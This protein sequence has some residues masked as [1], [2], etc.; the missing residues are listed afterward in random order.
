MKVL[1]KIKRLARRAARGVVLLAA[2][3][4]FLEIVMG[5]VGVP[6]WLAGWLTGAGVVLEA[7]PRYVVVLG[8]GG[9]P[10]GS[11]LMRTYYAA[12]VGAVYTGA[13][14]V[15]SLPARGDPETSSV[16]RMKQELVMRGIPR[17]SIRMEHEALNTREQA[18]N[19][20]R[21]LG[22][23][24]LDDAVLMVTSPEHVR[25]ALL[26]F[27]KAGFAQVAPLAALDT[28]AEADLGAMTGARYAFW[29]RLQTQVVFA[30]ELCALAVYKLRGWI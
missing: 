14:F 8:G 10:S 1:G 5:L 20:A 17:G 19:I 27:R 24:A 3:A 29:S 28:G 7:E 30:R 23:E 18:G 6:R 21:M 9:I 12:E 22:D 16:G 11:G 15:V 25:R 26:C 4:F 13:T 2:V